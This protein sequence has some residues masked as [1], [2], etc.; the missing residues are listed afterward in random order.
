MKY[1]ILVGD[2]MAGYPVDEL[3]GRTTLEAAATPEMDA[4]AATGELFTLTTVPDGMAPG[5]DVA[6]LS[7]LGYRPDTCYTGR[8]PLEAASM[9]VE[10]APGETAFR[11]N[12]VTVEHG[13]GDHLRMLDYSAG[14][15]TTSEAGEL[16]TALAAELED[17]S[18]ALHPGVSYRHLLVTTF[19]HDGLVTAPP[20]DHTG[21]DVTELR[22]A[23]D[24]YAFGELIRRAEAVLAVHPVNEERRRQGKAPAN[25]IWLWGEG[26]AR[27]WS[28][29]PI[30]M[31]SAA[32]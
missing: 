32:P 19:P 12:L 21:K 18:L 4:L 29:F 26:R 16:I 30:S 27:P 8:A 14:H 13:E 28:G 9:G 25:S 3:G 31:G 23:Y 15:I 22:R 24:R 11:C 17:D 2:G 10:L 7:L 20:H 6:N 1:V 5:S